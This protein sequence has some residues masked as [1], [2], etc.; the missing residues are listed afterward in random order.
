MIKTVLTCPLGS[1]CE[2]VRDGAIHRCAWHIQMSGTDPQTGEQK[3][4]RACAMSWLPLLLVENS[5]QQVRTTGAVESFRNETAASN[6]ETR[7]VMMVAAALSRPPQ[8][9]ATL[10]SMPTQAVIGNG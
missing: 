5:R 3:D 10:P 4:E 1:K 8:P 6:A 9:A 7:Q 2:E